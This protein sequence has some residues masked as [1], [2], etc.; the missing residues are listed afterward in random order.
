MSDVKVPLIIPAGPNRYRSL[1]IFWTIV[2]AIVIGGGATLQVMGPPVHPK[3][4][5]VYIAPGDEKPPEAARPPAPSGPV[6]P[7]LIPAPIP[8]LEEPAPDYAGYFLPIKG[9]DGKLPMVA[10]K[11]PFDAADKHPKVVLVIDGGGIDQDRTMHLLDDLPGPIDVAFSAYMPDDQAARLTAE[12]RKT[13]HECLQSVPME[14]N[15]FP[16]ADE[17]AKQ[18]MEK[19]DADTNRQYLEFSLSRVP[20]CVGITGASDG[21]A[22]ERFAQDGLSFSQ[23]LEE[24]GKR[25]LLYLDPRT[26]A[27]ALA[28]EPETAISVVDLT[29]DQSPTPE[30]AVTADVIDQRLGMLEKLA[31]LKGSAIGLAGPPTPVL[32]QHIAIWAHGLAARGVT[33]APLTAVQALPKPADEDAN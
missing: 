1:A 7:D 24:A 2:A 21:M 20:G 3:K 18:L 25:G 15:N 10:Y 19:Y 17:G 16:I 33:L 32:L 5:V 31:L 27:P 11:A 22:G 9:P 14:P 12:A 29:V 26:G 4:Q 30:Q 6:K 23:V 8:A 28:S 13:G